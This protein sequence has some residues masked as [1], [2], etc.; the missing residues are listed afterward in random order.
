MI[1]EFSKKWCTYRGNKWPRATLKFLVEEV[2]I[3]S[4]VSFL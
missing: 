4:L 2:S 3:P 1:E